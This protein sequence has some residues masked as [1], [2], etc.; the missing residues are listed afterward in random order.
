[1]AIKIFIP[2]RIWNYIV[3]NALEKKLFEIHFRFISIWI[4]YR[5]Y[6]RTG[7]IFTEIKSTYFL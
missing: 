5:L 4:R 1:M 6:R 7:N 2:T 3:Q